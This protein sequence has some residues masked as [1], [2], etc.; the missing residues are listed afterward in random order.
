MPKEIIFIYDEITPESRTQFIDKHRHTLIP[1]C[2]KTLEGKIDDLIAVPSSIREGMAYI[3]NLLRQQINPNERYDEIVRR[4]SYANHLL[5]N[6]YFYMN[7]LYDGLYDQGN[8]LITKKLIEKM[9]EQSTM[10]EDELQKSHIIKRLLKKDR[11]EQ[12]RIFA[13]YNK[14]VQDLYPL[15][16][17]S[18]NVLNLIKR[19]YE[20]QPLPH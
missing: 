7:K 11:K 14:I 12:L 20:E 16:E 6:H 9:Q 4:L 19:S 1:K 13:D 18:A 3:E 2:Y 8:L 15:L 5:N 17:E 10:L